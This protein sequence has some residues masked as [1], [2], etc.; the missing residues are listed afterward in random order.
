M[1][2][3]QDSN[4]PQADAEPASSGGVTWD[5]ILN[6]I[7]VYIALFLANVVMLLRS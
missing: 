4:Q 6:P 3:H 1:L 7:T 5:Q 2:Q